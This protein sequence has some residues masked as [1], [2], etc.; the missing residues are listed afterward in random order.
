MPRYSRWAAL[1]TPVLLLMGCRPSSPS[2]APWRVDLNAAGPVSFGAS[3]REA[4]IALRDSSSDTTSGCSLW[5]P[6]HAPPGLTLMVE[7]G[8]V[9]RVDVDSPGV[10][11]L[12]DLQVGSAAS[13]VREAFGAELSAEPH[14]YLWDAGWQYLTV[15]SSDA[16]HGLVFEVDSHVVRSYRAGLW[17]AVGYVERCS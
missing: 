8:V 10:R 17:P 2:S 11:T 16:I 3:L 4:A 7:K 15:R 6:T 13:A 12:H 5:R 9:A 1:I 14:K